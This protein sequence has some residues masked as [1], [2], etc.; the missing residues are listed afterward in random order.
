MR[1]HRSGAVWPSGN[2]SARRPLPGEP[3]PWTAPP[4]LHHGPGAGRRGASL[5]STLL[6]PCNYTWSDDVTETPMT[7]PTLA[8]AGVPAGA[9]VRDL[10]IWVWAVPVLPEGHTEEGL[11]QQGRTDLV[12]H[13]NREG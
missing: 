2:A 12:R 5:R 13:A 6:S 3:S 1:D 10:T 7:T 4:G 11:V 9:S 8:E